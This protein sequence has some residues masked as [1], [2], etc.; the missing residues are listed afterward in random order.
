MDKLKLLA[1]DGG[2]EM[3]TVA[4]FTTIKGLEN[5]NREGLLKKDDERTW[6]SI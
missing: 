1:N 4:M 5:V 3:Q 6:S 2:K